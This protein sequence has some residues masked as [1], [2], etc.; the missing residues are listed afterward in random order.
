MARNTSVT[1][2]GNRARYLASFQPKPHIS[3]LKYIYV[4][5]KVQQRSEYLSVGDW[6]IAILVETR[7]LLYRNAAGTGTSNQ[8]VVSFDIVLCN[9]IECYTKYKYKKSPNNVKIEN[10]SS[11]G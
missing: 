6:I 11:F 5:G 1:F 4:T 9:V 3:H 2:V 7:W 8:A 10:I